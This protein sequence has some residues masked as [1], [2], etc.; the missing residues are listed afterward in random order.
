MAC[1]AGQSCLADAEA[2]GLTRIN[3][4]ACV[5]RNVHEPDC[6]P[7]TRPLRRTAPRARLLRHAEPV[8]CRLGE[9]SCL[10]RFPGVGEHQRGH[11][12]RRRKGRRR[13]RSGLCAQSPPRP[14]PGD[15]PAAQRRFR[16]RLRPRRG[17]RARERAAL[18]RRRRLGLLDR[19]LYRRSR[20]P[21]IRRERSLRAAARGARGD[22]RER[23]DRA[24]D[25]AVRSRSCVRPEAFPRRCAAS[26]PTRRRAPTCSTRRY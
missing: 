20:R 9:I 24:S 25:R 10:P 17:G 11:G 8:R 26:P 6:R 22:Q 3:G 12:L 19:G 2:E 4:R 5:G 23:R 7:E 1:S 13:R 18:H 15:R 16:G 21:A 14:R